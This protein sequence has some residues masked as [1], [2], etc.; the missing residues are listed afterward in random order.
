MCLSITWGDSCLL[1]VGFLTYAK[2]LIFKTEDRH[3]FVCSCIKHLICP[4]AVSAGFV[5]TLCTVTSAFSPPPLLSGQRE[6]ERGQPSLVWLGSSDFQL[7]AHVSPFDGTSSAVW[8]RNSSDTFLNSGCFQRFVQKVSDEVTISDLVCFW[9]RRQRT[10]NLFIF[11]AICTY[12]PNLYTSFSSSALH[13]SSLSHILQARFMCE[14]YKKKIKK[15][16]MSTS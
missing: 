9:K 7:L 8:S 10:L 3:A 14:K 1:D 15:K 5:S 4:T 11:V 6:R 13:Y 12:P 2:E 16:S